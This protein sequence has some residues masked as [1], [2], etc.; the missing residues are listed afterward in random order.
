L[1]SLVLLL[2]KLFILIATIYIYCSYIFL[3]NLYLNFSFWKNRTDDVNK[4]I[5]VFYRL[6]IWRPLDICHEV[7]SVLGYVFDDDVK[8]AS[9]DE[10]YSRYIHL[11]TIKELQ[12]ECLIRPQRPWCRNLIFFNILIKY[13]VTILLFSYLPW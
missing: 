2:H 11:N 3:Y 12:S 13:L 6:N 4:I 7:I 10:I 1:A 8:L 9:I 5:S